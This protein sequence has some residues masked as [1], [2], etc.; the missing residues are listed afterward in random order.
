MPGSVIIS[1]GGIICRPTSGTIEEPNPEDGLTPSARKLL[2]SLR[3]DFPL[4]GATPSEALPLLGFESRTTY[5]RAKLVLLGKGL[6][7]EAGGWLYP[8][9]DVPPPDGTPPPGG[10]PDGTHSQADVPSTHGTS[11]GRC[12]TPPSRG[13]EGAARR[14]SE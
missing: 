12:T 3:T 1:V 13:H 9:D 8:S 2:D 10:T 5:Y 4:S 7:R 6:A 14:V 11:G